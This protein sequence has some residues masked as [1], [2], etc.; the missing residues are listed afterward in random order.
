MNFKNVVDLSLQY[1][2]PYVEGLA[3]ISDRI[4]LSH[5]A[6]LL[7]EDGEVVDPTWGNNLPHPVY[8]GTIVDPNED[9]TPVFTES[10]LFEQL[11]VEKGVPSEEV[12]S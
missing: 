12:W 5:H 9:G 4:E 2:A 10:E 11:N 6:W 1:D 3:S 8:I 7:D